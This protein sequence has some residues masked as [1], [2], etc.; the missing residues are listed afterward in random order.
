MEQNETIES[1]IEEAAQRVEE[2]YGDRAPFPTNPYSQGFEAGMQ[3][4]EQA[5]FEDAKKE[6]FYHDGYNDG[7]DDGVV[8]GKSDGLRFGRLEGARESKEDIENIR[9]ELEVLN[10]DYQALMNETMT[11][12]Q[13]YKDTRKKDLAIGFGVGLAAGATA[14]VLA[15]LREKKIKNHIIG[16]IE[17]ACIEFEQ[18]VETQGKNANIGELCQHLTVTVLDQ[19]VRSITNPFGISRKD[20]ERIMK[21]LVTLVV[22]TE[23]AVLNS[24]EMDVQNTEDIEAKVVTTPAQ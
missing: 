21:L 11:L 7:F 24:L 14:G 22:T 3:A 9:Q 1:I 16:M 18:Q 20:S 5:G 19:R 10:D 2:K 23:A 12:E 15:V 13:N 17:D 8:Q 6:T 4:G